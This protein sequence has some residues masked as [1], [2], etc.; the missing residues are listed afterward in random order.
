MGLGKYKPTLEELAKNYVYV[1]ETKHEKNKTYQIAVDF[2][3][4]ATGE[5][6]HARGYLLN[7]YC[8]RIQH[9]K[10]EKNE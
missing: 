1:S 5:N 4:Y 7:Y 8:E 3:K 6:A 2:I 9:Y 10:G